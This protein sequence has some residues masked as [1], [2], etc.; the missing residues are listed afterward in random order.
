MTTESTSV[1]QTARQSRTVVPVVPP[2]E[3]FDRLPPL[4]RRPPASRARRVLPLLL[5]DV[6]AALFGTLSLV[7]ACWYAPLLV[8]FAAG[9][10]TY[11]DARPVLDVLPALLRNV[12]FAWCAMATA[13][14]HAHALAPATLAAGAAL[15]LAL[16]CAGRGAVHAHRTRA[17]ARHLRPALVIGPRTSVRRVSTML[18]AHPEYGLRP[19]GTIGR[20]ST[21]EDIRHVVIRS[22]VRDAV[23]VNTERGELVRLFGECGCTVWLLDDHA[24]SGGPAQQRRHAGPRPDTAGHLWGFACRRVDPPAAPAA[25]RRP[26][27]TAKRLLDLLIAGLALLAAAPVLLACA[28]AVRACD[29]PGIMFRQVRVGQDGRRFVLLKFRTL[30]PADEHEA[31]T[32]WSVAQDRRM[33]ATGRFLRRTSLDELPQ[34]WNV[35]RGDMSLVGPRPERPYFVARFSRTHPGYASRHRMPVGI[36]GLAQIHGLRGDTSIEDRSRFDNHYIDNWSLWQDICILL[37]TAAS[38][39]R[40][41]GS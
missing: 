15:H 13:L 5:V 19:V 25:R 12:T 35:L 28:V 1:P 21:T 16:A 7:G 4:P 8:L 26:G 11:T 33:S 29:G 14:A 22:T 23:L 39:V 40:P 3:V 6:V 30:R 36:T 20:D 41:G 37:R 34:L 31:A 9:L 10:N 18:D 27:A 38:L 32:R 24:A 17:N 2:R